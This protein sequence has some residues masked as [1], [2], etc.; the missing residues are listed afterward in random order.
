MDTAKLVAVM[1]S[2]PDSTSITDWFLSKGPQVMVSLKD[3]APLIG[4]TT[5]SGTGAEVTCVAVVSDN[6]HRKDGVLVACNL[7]IVD[8]K[9]TATAPPRVTANSGFDAMAHALEAYTAGPYEPMTGMG[10]DPMASVLAKE[11]VSL[12][13]DNLEKCYDDGSDMEARIAMSK[14]SN[15]AGIAFSSA[16]VSF[17]HCIAH[18][19]GSAYGMPHGLAC[20]YTVPV[21]VYEN[22][23]MDKQVGLELAEMMRVEVS[24]TDDQQTIA[25]ALRDKVIAMMKHCHMP[26][27]S[28]NGIPTREAAVGCA[29]GAIA[30]HP[31]QFGNTV[32]PLTE[33]RFAELIGM[34]YD[35]AESL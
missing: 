10:K 28:D 2:H 1:L 33:E 14:A 12:I 32:K 35:I 4:V 17:G 22:A 23:L 8:P 16:G 9:L 7:A 26:H 27:I 15:F 31:E 25:N 30:N 5:S 34:V 21:T 11:A 18:E 20:A 13:V 3:H 6:D 29:A 24:A 19:F